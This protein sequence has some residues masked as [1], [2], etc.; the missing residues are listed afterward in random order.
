MSGATAYLPSEAD[1]LEKLTD[2]LTTKEWND[3]WAVYESRGYDSAVQI[4]NRY[5]S[6]FKARY[7][8]IGD[9]IDMAI[10]RLRSAATTAAQ[11]SG[12]TAIAKLIEALAAQL[13]PPIG[14]AG[15]TL[16]DSGDGSKLAKKQAPLDP[17]Q[18]P[19]FSDMRPR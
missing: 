15:T 14:R 1:Q 12:D 6:A 19:D 7:K 13:A 16:T 3:V 5:K 10:E 18:N 11:T 2:D 4:A 9:A 8:V 17:W